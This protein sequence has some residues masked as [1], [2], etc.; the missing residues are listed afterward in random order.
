MILNVLDENGNYV[1]IPAIVGPQGPQGPQGIQGPQGP[2]G[3]QGNGLTILGYYSSVSALIVAVPNP[4]VGDTYGI[5]S[6]P[7]YNLYA[8]DGALWIDNGQ[9]QGAKGEKGDKGDKGDTGE[10]GP[11]GIQG[12]QGPKGDTGEKGNK[13]EQGP[14]GKDGLTTSV[15]GVA[16]VNGEITII[17]KASVVLSA[18]GWNGNSQS[19]SVANV[20]AK[21]KVDIQ[22]DSAV[23]EQ[24]LN[25]EV[26]GLYI[27]N[28]A[29]TLTAKAVGGVPKADLT[30]Q[31]TLTE[32][33][34]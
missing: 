29:G 15:N 27:E 11:Q 23:I 16:Q 5:G 9:L 19:I 21:S 1:P 18:S 3:E 28:N 17:R 7:P 31:I 20:T 13:G 14:A 26:V 2:K 33:S 32:V 24:M 22:P 10:Q 12:I 6:A 34:E 25:D 4:N 8:W 30:L